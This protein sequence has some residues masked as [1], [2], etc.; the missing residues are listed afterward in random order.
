MQFDVDKMAART[1]MN[2]C[3]APLC[4][5]RL[6]WLRRF[7]V[8]GYRTISH[9]PVTK[10]KSEKA[11]K[12]TCGSSVRARAELK[13]KLLQRWRRTIGAGMRNRR[14][15][16]CHLHLIACVRKQKAA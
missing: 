4:H 12:V 11:M 5:G 8:T 14:V 10:L 9:V 2:C 13:I 6:H 7:Q 16:C 3:L 15:M 1:A